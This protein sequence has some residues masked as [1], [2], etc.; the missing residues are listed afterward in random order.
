MIVDNQWLAVVHV[1]VVYSNIHRH[2][3]HLAFGP[4]E[5]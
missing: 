1:V 5:K 4:F 3:V 2:I